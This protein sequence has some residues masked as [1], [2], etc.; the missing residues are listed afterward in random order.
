MQ[1]QNVKGMLGNWD[2][3]WKDKDGN[4]EIPEE[5]HPFEP[6]IRDV[7]GSSCVE[8][9]PL[10]STWGSHGV[11]RAPVQNTL[12]GWNSTDAGKITAPTLIIRGLRDVQAPE[13]P[14]RLLFADLK[15]AQKVFVRVACAG[16]QLLFENQHM[17]LLR[18]SEKWLRD[19]TFAGDDR[20]SY[21]DHGS[22]FVDAKGH[23]TAE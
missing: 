23:V 10:G 9:D 7:I 16:H 18:A 8:S 1:V 17:T 5:C 2:S 19:G 14:Q 6:E 12:W 11:W 22:Y 4:P 13:P 3:N 20:G 21:F 15:A